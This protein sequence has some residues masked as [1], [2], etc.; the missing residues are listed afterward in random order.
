MLS[1]PE[2]SRALT[3]DPAAAEIAAR[4]DTFLGEMLR[5][6]PD[7]TQSLMTELGI[8]MG[9][10]GEEQLLESYQGILEGLLSQSGLQD[11]V[12]NITR[13]IDTTIEEATRQT[14]TAEELL[15]ATEEA[16]SVRRETRFVDIPTPEEFLD[17]FETAIVTQADTL[18]RTGAIDQ[19]TKD[20]MINNPGFF[21]ADYLAD[22]GRRAQAG[23]DIFRVVGLD[24]QPVKIGERVGEAVSEEITSTLE[25]IRTG[26]LTIEDVV[27]R[28]I[29]RL[30][31]EA[32]TQQADGETGTSVQNLTENITEQVN[33]IFRQ[34]SAET[35]TEE[36]VQR[37]TS[38]TIEEVLQRPNLTTVFA[39]TPLDFLTER[40]SPTELMNIAAAVPGRQA[41]ARQQ[42]FGAVPSAPRRL[43]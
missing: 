33:E 29:E 17:N 4:A 28:T 2:T 38:F 9:M 7:E 25:A 8:E 20:F 39:F 30:V 11:I 36:R 34:F 1:D 41:A 31:G 22:L 24:Q 6:H 18:R 27:E 32:G 19:A 5:I 43:A 42:P 26:T 10:S 21:Y 13:D 3:E 15:R 37:L 16:V 40:F 35:S 23:E 14:R 12:E